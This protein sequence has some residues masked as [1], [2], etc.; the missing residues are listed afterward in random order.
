MY[1]LKSYTHF[2]YIYIYIYIYCTYVCICDIYIL[3]YYLAGTDIMKKYFFIYICHSISISDPCHGP[4]SARRVVSYIRRWNN[5]VFAEA[6]SKARP[7][8]DRETLVDEL[9]K[10][11]EAGLMHNGR[12][13]PDDMVQ[14]HLVIQKV[15]E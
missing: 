15:L 4:A 13:N 6:L 8:E 12:G 5:F 14:V 7:K 2:T 1:I 3:V 10:R 11:F 9:F